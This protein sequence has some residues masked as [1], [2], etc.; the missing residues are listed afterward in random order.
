MSVVERKMLHTR[1]VHQADC[2]EPT[3]RFVIFQLAHFR[4]SRKTIQINHYATSQ[5]AHKTYWH[6]PQLALR[7][8]YNIQ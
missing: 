1:K 4:Q 5:Q 7:V 2:A 6:V 3:Q 8:S